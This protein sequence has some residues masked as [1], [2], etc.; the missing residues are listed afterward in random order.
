M[1]ILEP[2]AAPIVINGSPSGVKTIVGDIE[3]RGLFAGLI[4]LASYPIRPKAF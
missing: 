4:E 2:P 3:L 1:I